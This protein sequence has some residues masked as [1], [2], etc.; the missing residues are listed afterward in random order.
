V[1]L[2]SP[3]RI[4]DTLNDL[5]TDPKNIVYV[6]SS[7]RPRDLESVFR[8]ASGLGF[9][10]ENGCIIRVHGF[11]S[12]EWKSYVDMEKVQAWK[13]DVKTILKYYVERMEGSHIEERTCSLLFH[14]AKVEDQEAATRQA[15]EC[16]D[17]INT[18]CQSMSIQAVPIAKAVL[19]EH[20]HISKA[21]A[22]ANILD[23]LRK[24]SESGAVV[25]PDFLMVAGDD[26]EDEVVFRWANELVEERAVQ[27]VFTVS[28]GKRN[29]EAQAI[30]TQGSSGLLTVLQKL[31]K[32]SLD[33]IPADYFSGRRKT[34]LG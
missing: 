9:I 1:P 10:A 30:L 23:Q 8:L 11:G 20:S 13:K 33:E 27:D 4:V 5:T 32:I 21:T 26:R 25:D 24:S 2:A 6:M 12:N 29:T 15:G 17:Q 34:L 7:R 22:T 18:S 19:I 28:V 14:Y 31:A 16:A 3:N